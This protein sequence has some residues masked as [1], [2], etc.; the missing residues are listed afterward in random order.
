MQE[1]HDL[2]ARIPRALRFRPKGM[3]ITGVAKQLGVTEYGLKAPRDPPDRGKG[4]RPE[5]RQCKAYSLVR[6]VP[7]SAFLCFTKKFLARIAMEL[8]DLSPE[9]DIYRYD[10]FPMS[11]LR[12]LV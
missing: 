11:G 3:A 12:R 10:L 2:P 9:A 1:E 7:I 5:P 8:A 4:R 6:R